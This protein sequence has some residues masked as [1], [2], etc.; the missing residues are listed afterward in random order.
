MAPQDHENRQV[1]GGS[2]PAAGR[3]GG[4]SQDHTTCTSSS[5]DQH[6]QDQGIISSSSRSRM[7]QE[8]M[9][10][11]SAYCHSLTERQLEVLTYMRWCDDATI[12]QV[13][14]QQM[15][16]ALYGWKHQYRHACCAALAMHHW[17]N[18]AATYNCIHKQGLL[19]SQLHTAAVSANVV[20]GYLQTDRTRT[21]G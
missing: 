19:N 14:V 3:T 21:Q 11:M 7:L 9:A 18:T 4:S 6:K 20:H 8:H 10:A 1:S 12:Q 17:A 2:L 5:S 15:T 16:Y 13:C